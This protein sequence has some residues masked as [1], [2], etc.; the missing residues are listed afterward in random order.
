MEGREGQF[1]RRRMR[2]RRS[3]FTLVELLVSIAIVALLLS[4]LATTFSAV[5]SATDSFMCKNK[6]LTVVRRFTLFADEYS[7]PFRGDDSAR[8]PAGRFF[9]EDF[10]QS[11]YEVDEFFTRDFPPIGSIPYDPD[12]QPLICP[13]GPQNLLREAHLQG[14]A[15][16]RP[17]ANVSVAMN[18]RLHQ[19]PV[20]IKDRWVLQSVKLDSQVLNHATTPLV[21]DVDG[22]VAADEY[23]RPPF[24]SAPAGD[25]PDEPYGSG[26]FWFP[27]FRHKDMMHVGFVGGHVGS[28]SSPTEEPGWDWGYQPPVDE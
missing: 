1:G 4:M 15:V 8:L 3:G 18:A 21:F 2:R 13:A 5:R 11:I 20:L 10:Q 6:L 23:D 22:R 26:E 16:V 24:F 25:N 9:L 7:Q 28:S 17:R 12:D 14:Q 27:S 19:G